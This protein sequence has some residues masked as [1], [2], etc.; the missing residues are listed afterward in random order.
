MTLR[1]WTPITRP[2]RCVVSDATYLAE[3]RQN[4][5]A[6]RRE[7]RLLPLTPAAAPIIVTTPQPDGAWVAA[8]QLLEGPGGGP[9][10][11]ATSLPAK[12]RWE[13]YGAIIRRE[14][15]DRLGLAPGRMRRGPGGCCL[16]RRFGKAVSWARR[17][18]SRDP[19]P[20]PDT[21]QLCRCAIAAHLGMALAQ[22][23]LAAP[24]YHRVEAL[25]P[26]GA[27]RKEV[28]DM[29]GFTILLNVRKRYRL[30]GSLDR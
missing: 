8:L 25:F 4:P 21:M 3:M 26:P 2:L 15:A 9:E 27:S 7:T 22:R 12:E 23:L 6:Q 1:S 24:H 5:G 28:T 19:E 11:G 18:A 20:A 13:N 16:P 29:A 10:D 17:S 14:L 30:F